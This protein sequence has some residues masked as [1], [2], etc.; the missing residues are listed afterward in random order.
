MRVVATREPMRVFTTLE[1]TSADT[2]RVAVFTGALRSD[3][4]E[5]V[6]EGDGAEE[7][8]LRAGDSADELVHLLESAMAAA[9]GGSGP[10][11]ART[12]HNP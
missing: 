7:Y 10:G 2:L 4:G 11:A 6:E 12:N 8:V 9:H 5:G 3:S 1:L